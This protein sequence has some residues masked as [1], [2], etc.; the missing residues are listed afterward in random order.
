MNKEFFDVAVALK[1]IRQQEKGT[2]V[3]SFSKKSNLKKYAIYLKAA[4]SV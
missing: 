3:P 4:N 1:I 2:E